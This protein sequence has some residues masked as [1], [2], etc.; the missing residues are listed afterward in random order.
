MKI[1][2]VRMIDKGLKG[3][4]I[5]F[6]KNEERGG[7]TFQNEYVARIKVPLNGVVRKAFLDLEKDFGVLLGLHEKVNFSTVEGISYRKGEGVVLS[8]R[9]SVGQW[10]EYMVKTMFVGEGSEYS[11]YDRLMDASDK[12]IE[13]VGLWM[14][15][16]TVPTAKQMLMDFREMG[17][18]GMTQALSEYNFDEMNAEDA[19]KKAVE[20]LEKMGAVVLMQEG[21]VNEF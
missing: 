1:T 11:N 13:V 19:Q 10:G 4:E 12:L 18:P 20:L 14:E 15:Q 7:L 17:K 9:I 6:L 8:G 3:L 16:S 21:T 2:K 5:T